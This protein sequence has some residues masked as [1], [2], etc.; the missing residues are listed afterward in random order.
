MA[1]TAGSDFDRVRKSGARASI[2][3]D[4]PVDAARVAALQ[5]AIPAGVTGELGRER[6][7]AAIRPYLSAWL[8]DELRRHDYGETLEVIE[9]LSDGGEDQGVLKFYQGECYRLRRADGDLARA[10]AAYQAAATHP[11]APVVV[12]REL[13]GIALKTNDKP[14]ARSALETYLAHAPQAEDAWLVR[15][16]LKG[17]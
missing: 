6:Y 4:H 8:R 12:W 7:R 9:H 1:E 10:Q 3:D 5:A 14:A 13:G 16:D 17:L 2:F 11:D 15:D